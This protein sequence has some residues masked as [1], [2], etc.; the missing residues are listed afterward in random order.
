MLYLET[1]SFDPTWNLAFEEYALEKLRQEDILILWRNDRSVIIG[2]NQNT[3]QEIDPA[4]V[5]AQGIQ[6]VRRN[7]GGGAVYHDLGNLNYSFITD[8]VQDDPLYAEKFVRPIVEALQRLGLDACASGRNDILVDGKKVSGTA[9]QISKGRILHHGTLLFDT[10]SAM[11]GGALNP[12]R[13]KF[14]SKGVKSVRSRVGSIRSALKQ[15]MQ[16]AEFMEFIRGALGAESLRSA[17]LRP[18]EIAAIKALQA[19]KYNTW[20]WNFGHSPKFDMQC[21]RRFAGGIL[22]IR[23]T[24]KNGAV[25]SIRIYGDYLCTADVGELE[26]LLCGCPLKEEALSARLGNIDLVP[27]LGSVTAGELILTLLNIT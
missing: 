3:L 20:E 8:A 13:S 9:R 19:E 1:G 4:F 7:T 27:Y 17:S 15:D 11:L 2:R 21:R 14:E 18:A 22:D 23:A 25:E 6:V 12:D 24:I 26:A 16:M 10:D 5:E